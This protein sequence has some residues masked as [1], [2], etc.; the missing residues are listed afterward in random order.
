MAVTLLAVI[1]ALA[2]GHLAPALAARMRQFGWFRSWLQWLYGQFPEH[3]FWRGPYGIALAL[4]VPLLP[5]ALLQ[6]GASRALWGLPG[7]L[8][9]DG[10]GGST[11]GG[12]QGENQ[13]GRI[14]GQ[15][16]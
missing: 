5:L 7:L 6:I 15:Q 16:R 8:F 10:R 1:V 2:I 11:G 13:G 12:G 4:A 14:H 9:G 3:G